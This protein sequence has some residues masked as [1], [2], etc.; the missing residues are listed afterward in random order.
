MSIAYLPQTDQRA[1]DYERLVRAGGTFAQREDR[2]FRHRELAFHALNAVDAVETL[3]FLKKGVNE[4]NPI[5]GKNPSPVMLIGTKTVGSLLH[6]FAIKKLRQNDPGL[7]KGAQIVSLGLMGGLV[8][9][10]AQFVF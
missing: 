6:H 2:G 7:A 3:I 10:N 1:R 4:A 5:Y 9:W 8:A